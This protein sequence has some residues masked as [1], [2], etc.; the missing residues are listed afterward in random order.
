VTRPRRHLDP[1]SLS[2]FQTFQ[3]TTRVA[4][5]IG[6]LAV[7]RL[8]KPALRLGACARCQNCASETDIQH[9][10]NCASNRT[11]TNSSAWCYVTQPALSAIRFS[12]KSFQL[13]SSTFF[14]IQSATPRNLQ[15]RG[16]DNVSQHSPPRRPLRQVPPRKTFS[17]LLLARICLLRLGQSNQSRSNQ[18]FVAAGLVRALVPHIIVVVAFLMRGERERGREGERRSVGMRPMGATGSVAA[19]RIRVLSTSELP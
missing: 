8:P 19:Q 14:N 6:P 10:P 4:G 18:R 3:T 9:W 16:G 11:S 1:I 12:L 13:R 2:K 15:T 7:Q 17:L 5:S